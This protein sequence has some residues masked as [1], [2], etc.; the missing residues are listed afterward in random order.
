MLLNE[1][2]LVVQ[3]PQHRRSLESIVKILNEGQRWGK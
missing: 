1:G 2:H 3:V